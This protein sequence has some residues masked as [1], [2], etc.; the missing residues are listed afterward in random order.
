MSK[1]LAG[2][3]S[4]V[5]RSVTN[6]SSGANPVSFTRHQW[7]YHSKITYCKT[8]L[9]FSQRFICSSNNAQES[10]R[11]NLVYSGSAHKY[12]SW[13]KMIWQH[14]EFLKTDEKS[15]NTHIQNVSVWRIK[16]VLMFTKFK[17][18]SFPFFLFL[19]KGLVLL[20]HWVF[21]IW[22]MYLLEEYSYNLLWKYRK[23]CR[24]PIG[25]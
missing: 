13:F 10:K 6:H 12:K 23:K 20:F 5:Y 2:H 8:A 7:N 3:S 19:T 17:F 22:I 4:F 11:I 15:I 25:R 21:W 18:Q 1:I 16:L 14:F 9:P 24:L